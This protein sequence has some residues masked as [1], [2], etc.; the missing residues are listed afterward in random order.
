MADHFL[1][2]TENQK[3]FVQSLS[4]H[5]QGVSDLAA[6]FAKVFGAQESTVIDTAIKKTK[7]A[8]FLIQRMLSSLPFVAPR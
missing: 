4:S 3:G 2:H 1:A 6:A 7:I 8:P 5:L